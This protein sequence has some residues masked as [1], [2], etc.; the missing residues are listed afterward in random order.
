MSEQIVAD[1]MMRTPRATKE[2][3]LN[4]YVKAGLLEPSREH[5]VRQ[6]QY[7]RLLRL[8]EG[9]EP[10]KAKD[11]ATWLEHNVEVVRRRMQEEKIYDAAGCAD[12][13]C[14]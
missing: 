3:I 6:E 7:R 12:V 1:R 14:A 9:P 10:A 2:R 11:V 5:K 8:Y 13:Y 4:L